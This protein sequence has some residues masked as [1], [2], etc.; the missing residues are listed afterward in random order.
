MKSNK[1]W[2]GIGLIPIDLGVIGNLGVAETHKYKPHPSPLFAS[3]SFPFSHSRK[4][5]KSRAKYREQ[6]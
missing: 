6:R 4:F 2:T 3:T 5:G 1:K